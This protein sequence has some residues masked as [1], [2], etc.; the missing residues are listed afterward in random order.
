MTL[1]EMLSDV[2]IGDAATNSIQAGV[3]AA[4]IRLPYDKRCAAITKIGRRCRG[5]IRPGREVCVFHDP[6]LIEKRRLAAARNGRP[7]H[8]KLS[9]LPDG[10]LRK[11]SNPTAVGQAMDRLYREVRLQ[12]I[13]PEMARVLFNILTRLLDSGIVEKDGKPRV[14]TGR[15]RADRLRPKLTHLL[16]RTER[17]AWRLA[18]VHATTTPKETSERRAVSASAKTGRRKRPDPFSDTAL[19]LALSAAS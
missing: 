8:R 7:K 10:Y 11:L 9:N 15:R 13:T 19:R 12:L 6:E 17:K 1:W 5:K 3:V 2:S 18:V 4:T 14:A 16:S